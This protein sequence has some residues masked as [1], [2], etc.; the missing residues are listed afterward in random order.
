MKLA[1][2]LHNLDA[3]KKYLL[4]IS[5]GVDSMVLLHLFLHSPYIFSVAHCN[6]QLR[7]EESSLDEQLVHEYCKKYDIKFFVKTFDTLQLKKNRESVEM[8]ARDLRYNYFKE[9]LDDYQFDYLVTAHHLNDNIETFF[10]NLL[11]GSGLKGLAGMQ[12]ENN[13]VLRPLLCFSRREIMDFA[14]ENKIGWRED[15]TNQTLD[16]LRNKIR[17]KIIPELEG[18][19]PVFLHQAE[20]SMKIIGEAQQFI[21]EKTQELKTEAQIFRKEKITAFS[22]E[23]LKKAEFVLAYNFLSEYGFTHKQDCQNLINAQTGTVFESKTHKIWADRGR[24]LVGEIS[25]VEKEEVSIG[26]DSIPFEIKKPVE[27]KLLPSDG[28]LK[29]KGEVVD[30]DKV[31]LPLVLRN[32]KEGDVFYPVNGKGKKKVSKFLKDEKISNYEKEKVLVL[33]DCSGAII[34]LV[35]FRLDDR[36]KISKESK[37]YLHLLLDD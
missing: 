14:I 22:L 37:K 15:Q 29:E 31:S 12:E 26:I 3:E 17:H 24:L 2:A 16:Y 13:A 28:G 20:K 27:L 30:Y 7:G 8:L 34:W 4:A 10:I 23:K 9:L 18:I 11:R 35:G 33:C 6:F 32:W 1:E 5:G 25:D 19:N 36:F 21:E